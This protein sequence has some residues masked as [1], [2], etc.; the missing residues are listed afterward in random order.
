MTWAKEEK[1]LRNRRKSR[2]RPENWDLNIIVFFSKKELSAILPHSFSAAL[3]DK[4]HEKIPHAAT[5]TRGREREPHKI[6][7]LIWLNILRLSYFIVRYWYGY[8]QH[9]SSS[10][11]AREIK[12]PAI[13]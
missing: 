8:R 7:N 6:R 12:M 2:Y 3:S 4:Q 9:Q 11:L 13:S 1:K 5:D 10:L